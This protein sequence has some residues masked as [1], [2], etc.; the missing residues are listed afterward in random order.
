MWLVLVVFFRGLGLLRRGHGCGGESFL[1]FPATGCHLVECS[2][3]SAFMPLSERGTA[4]EG[5]LLR[6]LLA[7]DEEDSTSKEDERNTSNGHEELAVRTRER[8]GRHVRLRVL[9]L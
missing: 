5:S 6:A 7:G 8:Q 9:D 2:P 1:G 4:F 3:A